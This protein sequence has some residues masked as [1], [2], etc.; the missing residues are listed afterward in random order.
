MTVAPI[1]SLSFNQ[2]KPLLD[3][4]NATVNTIHAARQTGILIFQYAEPAFDLAHIFAQPIRRTA[5][6]A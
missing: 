1:S 4:L 3:P 5:D 6:V 2:F